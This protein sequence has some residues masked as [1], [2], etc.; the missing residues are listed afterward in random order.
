V[1]HSD[2]WRQECAA[3]R[4]ENARRRDR[5]LA[6]PD[7]VARLV[8]VLGLTDPARW[9]GW[10][11][12]KTLPEQECV[13]CRAGSCGSAGHRAAANRAY[14]R[15]Q[16]VEIAGEAYRRETQPALDELDLELRE[17]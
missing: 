5:V 1:T 12:P 2:Q 6:H 11:P 3:V 14:H 9:S 4:L 15:R 8:E 13:E 7:L 17:Q 10:I 16:L